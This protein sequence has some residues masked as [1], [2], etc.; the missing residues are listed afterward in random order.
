MRVPYDTDDGFDS[1]TGGADSWEVTQLAERIA[2]SDPVAGSSPAFP[3]TP[4]RFDEP[5]TPY[6][7]F[8]VHVLLLLWALAS[9]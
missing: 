1:R 6:Q 3:A 9:T 2:V 8:V 4:E 5:L 7:H